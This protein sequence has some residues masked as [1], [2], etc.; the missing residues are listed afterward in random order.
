[1]GLD[2][3]MYYFPPNPTNSVHPNYLHYQV[4]FTHLVEN[5]EASLVILTSCVKMQADSVSIIARYI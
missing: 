2:A 3:Q 1:M 5:Q 4:P